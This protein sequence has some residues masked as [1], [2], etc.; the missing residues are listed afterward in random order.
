M[1]SRINKRGQME[2]SFQ[3][4]FSII[5]IAVFIYAAFYGIRYFLERADQ[6]QVGQF[7]A[8]LKSDVNNAWQS[9]ETSN[10]YTFNLPDGVKKVCFSNFNYLSYNK[11]YCPE[12]EIY[13]TAAQREGSNVF[14]CPPSGAS[15]VG[16][17][18][19]FRIDCDGTDC[20]RFPAKQPYCL[21]NNNGV[22]ITLER[23]LGEAFVKLK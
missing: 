21:S 8:D 10:V 17:P 11:S 22:T 20:L 16:A 6:V 18:V 9:T 23:N 2:M 3:L 1:V 19:H 4:I 15:N 5:L 14:F 13:R 7:L 12:F